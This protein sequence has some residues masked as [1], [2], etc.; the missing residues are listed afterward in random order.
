MS[1]PWRYLHKAVRTMEMLLSIF[2]PS[3]QCFVLH[4]RTNDDRT[5]WT[6]IARHLCF[7]SSF[8]FH[9]F[10]SLLF[11]CAPKRGF[12]KFYYYF[13]F[14]SEIMFSLFNTLCC[15]RIKRRD[16]KVCMRVGKKHC[17]FLSDEQSS[18]N[19]KTRWNKGKSW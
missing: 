1:H 11:Q 15:V 14:Q 9:T 6:R 16:G 10:F 2:H 12:I 4:S 8:H 5:R 7:F 3:K 17:W 13:S 18:L 19:L